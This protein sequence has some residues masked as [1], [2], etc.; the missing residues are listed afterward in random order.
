MQKYCQENATTAQS[1]QSHTNETVLS[2][3]WQLKESNLIPTLDK[4]INIET[5]ENFLNFDWKPDYSSLRLT[6]GL[7][8]L[9]CA[10]CALL[11]INCNILKT[12]ELPRNRLAWNSISRKRNENIDKPQE[13]SI[14]S[15][16]S[17]A[18]TTK[19]KQKKYEDESALIVVDTVHTVHRIHKLKAQ[20]QHQHQRAL[21][22]KQ[23][24]R[25]SITSKERR[26]WFTLSE[27]EEKCVAYNISTVLNRWFVELLY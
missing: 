9:L 10:H 11:C 25:F 12:S 23:Q 5:A 7:I 22:I 4:F 3:N 2:A 20:D 16:V 27:E 8:H 1:T 17:A 13:I 15:K 19:V 14:Y 24:I 18:A 6:F 26:K 21:A